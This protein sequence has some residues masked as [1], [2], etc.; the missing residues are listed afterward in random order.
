LLARR[1]F[2]RDLLLSLVPEPARCLDDLQDC[3][4]RVDLLR[5]LP[6]LVLLEIL[7]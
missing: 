4:E 2:L 3:R 7:H 5:R 6:E 1:R